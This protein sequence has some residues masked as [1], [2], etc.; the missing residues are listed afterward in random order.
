[1]DFEL[2]NENPAAFFLLA[3]V[4]LIITLVAYCA[5]PLIFAKVRKK[6]ITKK[7]YR[8]LCFVVNFFVMAMF[9]AWNG[10]IGTG[11]PYVLWT[12]V[13]SA[14]GVKILNNRFIINTPSTE[15]SENNITE[16]SV[17]SAPIQPTSSEIEL[18]IPSVEDEPVIYFCRKCG[19]KLLE[20][21]L[22]CHRC[23]VRVIKE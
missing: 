11:A 21:A 7:R 18:D 14:V 10:E 13:F 2:F 20:G 12:T 23:G 19:V 9:I 4:S 17:V 6:G 8:V 1:M 5:F 16:G 22:F 3:I 15:I